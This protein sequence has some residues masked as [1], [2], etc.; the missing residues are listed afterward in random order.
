MGN[1]GMEI[2]RSN[3]TTYGFE[4]DVW[5]YN[6]K[7]YIYTTERMIMKSLKNQYIFLII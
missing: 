5:M 2:L 4:N 7:W 1:F 6:Y 3:M